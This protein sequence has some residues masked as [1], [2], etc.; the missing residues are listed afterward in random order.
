MGERERKREEERGRESNLRSST[1]RN[2]RKEARRK[3]QKEKELRAKGMKPHEGE[4]VYVEKIEKNRKCF[5]RVILQ[6]K[7]RRNGRK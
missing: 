3:R 7:N 4:I 6:G 1:K 2:R 5:L